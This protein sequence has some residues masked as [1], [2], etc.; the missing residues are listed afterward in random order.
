MIKIDIKN[1]KLQI[2]EMEEVLDKHSTQKPRSE[3]RA[4]H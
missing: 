3:N 1:Q 4:K 2:F